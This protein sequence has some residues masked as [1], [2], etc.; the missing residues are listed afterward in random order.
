MSNKTPR[1]L[2]IVFVLVC[3]ASPTQIDLE[4]RQLPVP[5]EIKSVEGLHPNEVTMQVLKTSEPII[6][7]TWLAMDSKDTLYVTSGDGND[8]VLYAIET[9]SGEVNKYKSGAIDRKNTEE[10]SIPPRFSDFAIQ[11]FTS[12]RKAFV[13]NV[14]FFQKYPIIAVDGGDNVY[15]VLPYIKKMFGPDDASWQLHKITFAEPSSLFDV[16]YEVIYTEG[17]YILDN[18]DVLVSN[19]KDLLVNSEGFFVG[20]FDSGNSIVKF[21]GSQYE[22]FYLPDSSVPNQFRLYTS[23][24]LTSLAIDTESCYWV[25]VSTLPVKDNFGRVE[26]LNSS[27]GNVEIYNTL[28]PLFLMPSDIVTDRHNNAYVSD[29][30]KNR[31]IKITSNPRKE[32][33]LIDNAEASANT[34]SL[35]TPNGLAWDSKGN[36]YV[37]DTGNNAIQVIKPTERN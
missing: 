18:Q 21:K 30:L 5:L 29:S 3:C 33:V 26:R 2:L 27:T 10:I 16:G 19:P 36:L 20:G 23:S 12:L 37:A 1:L 32:E 8:S 7:P 17:K 22:E 11:Q 13:K 34:S 15:V 31:I 4:T 14:A 28:N 24:G 25:T 9:S 35:N 6:H